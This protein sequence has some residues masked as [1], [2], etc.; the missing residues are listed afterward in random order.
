MGAER[1]YAVALTASWTAFL[2]MGLFDLTFFKDWVWLILWVLIA[3]SARLSTLRVD[4]AGCGEPR[5]PANS[6]T[7]QPAG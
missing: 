1:D 3:L 4:D 6:P 2:V 7:R 5:A